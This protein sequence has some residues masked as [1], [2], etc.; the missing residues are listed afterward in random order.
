MKTKCL[1]QHGHLLGEEDHQY[2][3][4][5][6]IKPHP[7]NAWQSPKNPVAHTKMHKPFVIKM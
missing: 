5:I 1:K 4:D 6:K 7:K 2:A 3:T